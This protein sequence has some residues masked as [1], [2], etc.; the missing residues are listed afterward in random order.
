MIERQP[1]RLGLVQV[2]TGNGKG[3]TTAALGQAMRAAGHG[4][5]VMV[6]QFLKGGIEAGEHK[7]VARHPA[8]E[9]VRTIDRDVLRADETK[10]TAAARSALDRARTAVRDE[11][12]DLIVLDEVLVAAA[13]GLIAEQEVIELVQSR[14]P[15][16]ELV[17]TGRYTS[18]AIIELA[19]TVTD[20]QDVKHHYRA[21]VRMAPGR[22][23]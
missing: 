9:I 11:Q 18:A 8:F 14:R 4:L 10:R 23:Y 5:R 12:Y 17:L 21:G 22:D 2:Y 19:D 3:K 6:I 7:F 15:G 13:K 20:M 1:G 16:L